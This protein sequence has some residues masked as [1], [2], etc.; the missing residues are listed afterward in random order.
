M[1]PAIAIQKEET[2]SD[3]KYPLKKYS[4]T[5]QTKKGEQQKQAEVYNPGDAATVL[6]YNPEKGTVILIKQFRLPSYLNQNE[7]GMLLEA[8]AGKMEDESLEAC[9]RRESEEE[10]G[11]RIGELKKL[12]QVYMTPG[13]V[14][15]RVHFFTAP[16]NEQSRVSAGGG[17]E[18]E[19]EEVEVM[20]IDFQDAL[21]MIESGEIQD[22]KTIILLLYA[23]INGYFPLTPTSPA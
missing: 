1:Q 22:A 23:Q 9:I 6:L 12:F 2:L 14:T 3:N 5:R 8:C 11:Y 21:E 20:E 19:Q 10:T 17:L 4:F 16:Y 15:E 13:A 7:S 18:I